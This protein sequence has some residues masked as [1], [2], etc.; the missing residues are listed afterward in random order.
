MS[1][2]LGTCGLVVFKFL[3]IG[4]EL[5]VGYF[6]PYGHFDLEAGQFSDLFWKQVFCDLLWKQVFCDLA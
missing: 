6:R 1:A 2:L 4:F 5:K 3:N